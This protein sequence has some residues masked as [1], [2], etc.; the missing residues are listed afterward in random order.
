MCRKSLGFTL[1]EMLV[2]IAIIGILA[3][4]AIPQFVKHKRQAAQ[5]HAETDLRNC[6]T[7]AAALGILNSTISLDC[8]SLPGN[9]LSCII[10]IPPNRGDLTLNGP[11]TSTYNG[12]SITCT[13]TKN[14][15]TCHF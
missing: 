5:A 4:I 15:G 14:V 8:S 3:A 9:L 2:V 6:M 7:E 11:C 12:L 1:V 10:I 13:V